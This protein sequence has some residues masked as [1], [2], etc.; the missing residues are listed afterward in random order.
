MAGRVAPET[1]GARHFDSLG[2]EHGTGEAASLQRRAS[3][4]KCQMFAFLFVLLVAWTIFRL[5]WN[6]GKIIH[7]SGNV[8]MFYDD[9]WPLGLRLFDGILRPVISSLSLGVF[10]SLRDVEHLMVITFLGC[11]MVAIISAAVELIM[12]TDSV[13]SSDMESSLQFYRMATRLAL[14]LVT[15]TQLFA[16]D[17][18][19]LGIC[20]VIF[21]VLALLGSLL[22]EILFWI[23]W[24][25]YI[26]VVA[27]TLFYEAH[28]KQKMFQKKKSKDKDFNRHVAR[29]LRLLRLGGVLTIIDGLYVPS[30]AET[31]LSPS[32]GFTLDNLIVFACMFVKGG[33]FGGNEMVD[34]LQV[35]HELGYLARTNGKRVAFPGR[36]NLDSQDCIVSFP[37]KYADETGLCVG[38]GEGLGIQ[39]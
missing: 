19:I 1:F 25:L 14:L 6:V 35:I 2:T 37:G 4:G 24:V 33:F 9:R 20:A 27:T 10:A 32:L 34:Q 30:R 13:P 18:C 17:R 5:A 38:D 7:P 31:I 29:T 39:Y 22:L 23:G 11:F 28:V 21:F 15:L 3:L 16:F 8:E 12:A 36:V 26:T